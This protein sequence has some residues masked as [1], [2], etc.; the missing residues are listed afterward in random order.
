MLLS[1]YPRPSLDVLMPDP[2]FCGRLLEPIKIAA[3]AEGA[4]LSASPHGPASPAGTAAAAQVCA[5]LPNVPI[6]EFSQGE[7]PWRRERIDPPEQIVDSALPLSEQPG[8]GIAI[9]DRTAKKYAVS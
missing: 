1:L 3:M 6:L 5:T 4:G 2:K 9:N 8:F 7:V